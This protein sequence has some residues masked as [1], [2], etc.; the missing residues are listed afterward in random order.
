MIL[1]SNLDSE[2]DKYKSDFDDYIKTNSIEIFN[3]EYQFNSYIIDILTTQ[4]DNFM[5]TVKNS[6]Y[7]DHCVIFGYVRKWN[8]KFDIIPERYAT[9][10][11]A[12]NKC[13]DDADYVLVELED[14]IIKVKA[15]H[16]DGTNQFEIKSM[17]K[18]GKE[19]INID[20]NKPCYYK[21][22]KGL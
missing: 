22:I 5:D 3:Y 15:T 14:G 21:I 13:F 2:T 16:H 6:I 1:F 11:Q 19:G 17:N 10:E 8:G 9:L 18:L 20:L 4:F 12:L 7:N